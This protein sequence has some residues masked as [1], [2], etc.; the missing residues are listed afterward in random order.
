MLLRA[1]QHHTA[2]AAA[3]S[4]SS[5]HA[6][7]Q[8]APDAFAGSRVIVTGASSGIGK[9]VA[10]AYHAHGAKVCLLARRLEVMERIIGEELGGG[11]GRAFALKC[12]VM[13]V[14]GLKG[15]IAACAEKMGGIDILVNNAGG[16]AMFSR[17]EDELFSAECFRS[18]FDLN[19]T[20]ALVASQAAVPFLKESKGSI[21]N[22]SSLA[23]QN[24]S[25]NMPS[26]N[27]AKAALNS[28]TRS[29]ALT[30]APF[31][32][33]A[34]SL[35]PAVIQTPIFTPWGLDDAA[36]QGMG[37]LH[38]IGRVGQP[39]ECAAAVFY[40]TSKLAGFVT[41]EHLY[42]DGGAQITSS[43]WTRSGTLGVLGEDKAAAKEAAPE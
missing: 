40:L 6:L 2:A 25:S 17:N 20:S 38:P 19:V 30:L 42:V 43:F 4:S 7:A 11:D 21:V 14:D 28:L 1:I 36:V 3:S 24:G 9:A 8:W 26:Y 15:V 27:A 39:P 37:A 12:D 5:S 32:V 31:G 10:S 16:V 13:D 41:G 18:T 29:Q 22:V 33:R 34:N 35:N 23:A